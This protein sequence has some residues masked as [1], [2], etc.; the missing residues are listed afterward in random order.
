M[1]REAKHGH[2][3]TFDVRERGSLRLRRDGASFLVEGQIGARRVC[4]VGRTLY[5]GQTLFQDAIK[6]LCAAAP[7]S[8]AN[9]RS[10]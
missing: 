3:E 1:S 10:L 9:A 8:Y 6:A 7:Y 2:I 5:D 4:M